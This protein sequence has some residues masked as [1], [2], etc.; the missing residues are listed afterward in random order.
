[1]Y[2]LWGAAA[3][4]QGPAAPLPPPPPPLPLLPPLLEAGP[5]MS[6]RRTESALSV[7][8]VDEGADREGEAGIARPRALHG[9]EVSWRGPSFCNC[10]DF[11][12]RHAC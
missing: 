7:H 4:A 6:A 1:M 5:R 2:A 9:A 12:Y 8:A 3:G 10:T 11:S